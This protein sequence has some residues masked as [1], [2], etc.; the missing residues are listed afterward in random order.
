VQI[1]FN[2]KS[3]E[4]KNFNEK[5]L[6]YAYDKLV[7]G[8]N[9]QQEYLQ[10]LQCVFNVQIASREQANAYITDHRIKEITLEKGGTS[11]LLCKY[12]FDFN[13]QETGT[14]IMKNLGILLQLNDDLFDVYEDIQNGF[15]TLVTRCT[16]AHAIEAFV[17]IYSAQIEQKIASLSLTKKWKKRFSVRMAAVLALSQMVIIQLKNIQGNEK[18]LRPLGDLPRKALIVDMEKMSNRWALIKITYQFYRKMVFNA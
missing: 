6:L 1:S 16:D 11:V 12:F 18:R 9:N 5:I 3:Y 15:H 4:A 2:P 7:V 10:T 14:D 13:I 8:V 17:A